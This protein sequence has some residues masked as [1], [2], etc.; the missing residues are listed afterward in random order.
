VELEVKG[1][2]GPNEEDRLRR[3]SRAFIEHLLSQ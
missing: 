1:V 3:Q 2:T